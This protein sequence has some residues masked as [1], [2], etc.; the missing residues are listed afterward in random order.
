MWKQNP[1]A[2]AIDAF[3]FNWVGEVVYAF[4]PTFFLYK[5]LFRIKKEGVNNDSIFGIS[6]GCDRPCIN[7]LCSLA[8]HGSK[9]DVFSSEINNI[10]Y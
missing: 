2:V 8:P 4:L 3:T 10:P 1:L 6:R 7:G 9:L 5:T